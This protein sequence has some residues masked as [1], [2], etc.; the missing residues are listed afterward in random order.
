MSAD[1]G[2]KQPE[3]GTRNTSRVLIY[4][5]APPAYD[6]GYAEEAGRVGTAVDGQAIRTVSVPADKVAHQTGRFKSGLYLATTDE[7]VM[8]RA[9]V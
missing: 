5:T 7:E 4:T 8:E 6:Y 9:K 1:E 2:Q 3:E